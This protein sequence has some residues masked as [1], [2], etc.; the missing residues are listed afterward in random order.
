MQKWEH[1]CKVYLICYKIF[2]YI[3]K[4]KAYTLHHHHHDVFFDELLEDDVFTPNTPKSPRVS[5]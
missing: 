4:V 1:L 5:V 2:N 3:H